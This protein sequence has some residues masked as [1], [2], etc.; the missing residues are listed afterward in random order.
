MSS[1]S[2]EAASL[3]DALGEAGEYGREE[4]D[5]YLETK[6]VWTALS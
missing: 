2:S 1:P 6:T 4:L 5:S 3:P